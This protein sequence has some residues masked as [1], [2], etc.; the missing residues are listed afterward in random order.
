[1]LVGGSATPLILDAEVARRMIGEIKQLVT[2]EGGSLL[3]TTSPRTSREAADVIEA[4]MPANG[5]FHRWVPGGQSNPYPAI[6]GLA[7]H[8][9]VTGDSISMLTEVVR[10]GKP[11]AIYPLPFAR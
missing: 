8:F 9:I 10:Q 4:G 2:R 1:M 7:D 6:L 3:V 5:F 11:P